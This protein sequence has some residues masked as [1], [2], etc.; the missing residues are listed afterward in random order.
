[1][2]YL[3]GV[4]V[5]A[6]AVAIGGIAYAAIPGPDGVIHGCYKG[7]GTLRVV[8]HDVACKTNETRLT[9]NQTGP[10]GP[11]GPQGP[12]GEPGSVRNLTARNTSGSPNATVSAAT[13]F[14]QP[15]EIATGGGVRAD[16]SDGAF[17]V[18]GYSVPQHTATGTPTGWSGE[19][20]NLGSGTVAAVV[21][22]I[23]ATG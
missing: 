7:D 14:C 9:W 15:G 22:V 18:T 19:V 23:C 12:Q 17:P 5:A 1:M 4:L 6:L 16:L 3:I 10:Q 13:I 2:K 21:Y 20:R 8:D 11:A